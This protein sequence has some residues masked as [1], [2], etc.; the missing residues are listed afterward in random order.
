MRRHWW[1]WVGSNEVV[2]KADWSLIASCNLGI[3]KLPPACSHDTA[4]RPASHNHLIS[5]LPAFICTFRQQKRRPRPEG[6]Q[7]QQSMPP[8]TFGSKSVL[9]VFPCTLLSARFL[10]ISW[11]VVI[12]VYNCKSGA[13][14]HTSVQLFLHGMIEIHRACVTWRTTSSCLCFGARSS[15]GFSIR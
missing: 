12:H 1:T 5:C 10:T 3:R 9:S 13:C 2:G 14:T 15:I 11:H 8:M 7:R 6:T 4:W